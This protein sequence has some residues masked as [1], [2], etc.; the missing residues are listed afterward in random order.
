MDYDKLFDGG[1]LKGYSGR[2]TIT[3]SV[4]DASHSAY[5]LLFAPVV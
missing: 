4:M 2:V 1:A 3:R 5:A